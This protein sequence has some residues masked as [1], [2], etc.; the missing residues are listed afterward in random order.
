MQLKKTIKKYFQNLFFLRYTREFVNRPGLIRD[1][2]TFKK[3]ASVKNSQ[4]SLK[5]I[6]IIANENTN[7]TQFDTHY[8][9]HP[10]WAA[11]II[12]RINPD[13]HID[14][15]SILSFSTQLSAF[16]PTDFFDYRPA[17]L[18]LSNLNSQKANLCC[19]HFENNS[20]K[21]LSCMHTVEHIG[22]GRYGDEIDFEGDLKAINELQ[23]VLAYDGNL[24]FVVP[25]GK[26]VIQFNAHRVYSYQNIIEMFNQLNLVE[27]S[28]IPDNAINEGIINN[29]DPKI[30]ESQNYGCG[31][32]WFTKKE[33]T[34]ISLLPN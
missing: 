12:K 27:F 6:L 24:L 33:A 31:C 32:F 8:V 23:R 5:N 34:T 21:S 10:A 25:V 28:L 19:L 20:V 3:E 26:P 16:I 22:L 2:L 18:N 30:V 13:K 9:Y 17:N 11:R 4:I 15:S 1:F 14:I 7:H 29:A